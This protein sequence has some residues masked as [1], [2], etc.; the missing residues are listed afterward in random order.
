MLLKRKLF[1]WAVLVLFSAGLMACGGGSPSKKILGKWQGD[2]ELF[3]NSEEYKE[4]EKNPMGGMAK[5][6]MEMIGNMKLDIAADTITVELDFMGQNKKEVSKYKVT[7]ETSD[8]VTVENVSGKNK[9]SKSVITIIDATHIKLTEE[10]K[11]DKP[12]MTF[13]KI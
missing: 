3:K 4:M 9:G 6:F 10:G 1:I 7:A 13:K 8:S 12:G 5:M 11:D 2:I